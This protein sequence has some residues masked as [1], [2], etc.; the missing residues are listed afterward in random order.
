MS[1]PTRRIRCAFRCPVV[2]SAALQQKSVG[3]SPTETRHSLAT[4]VQVGVGAGKRRRKRRTQENASE[5]RKSELHQATVFRKSLASR[6][7][8]MDGLKKT[9]VHPRRG[10]SAL[11]RGRRGGVRCLVGR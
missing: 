10:C 3:T 1:S 9:G 7:M 5:V 6:G 11:T 2:G 8:S 4:V